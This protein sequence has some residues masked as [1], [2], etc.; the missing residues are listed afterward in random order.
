MAWYNSLNIA[1]D[2]MSGFLNS[3]APQ[4][5]SPWGNLPTAS[6]PWSAP[7]QAPWRMSPWQTQGMPSGYAVSPADAPPQ[8]PQPQQW[9]PPPAPDLGGDLLPAGKSTDIPNFQ[10]EQPG[11]NFYPELIQPKQPAP[12]APAPPPPPAPPPRYELVRNPWTGKATDDTAGFDPME[13]YSIQPV[14]R[15]PNSR[16]NYNNPLYERMMAANRRSL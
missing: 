11:G 8:Q 12:A 13:G 7:N 1:G 4:P 10:P 6:Q 2:E 16:I 15:N 9:Q 14:R 3:S 5:S